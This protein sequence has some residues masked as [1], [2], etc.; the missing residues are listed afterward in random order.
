MSAKSAKHRPSVPL[1]TPAVPV[2]ST[3][4]A[5][6]STS[7]A[8]NWWRA[9]SYL[10]RCM[11]WSDSASFVHDMGS[12]PSEQHRL[13]HTGEACLSCGRCMECKTHRRKCNVVWSDSTP[14]A[15]EILVPGPDG[16]PMSLAAHGRR[17]GITRAAAS[18][19]YQRGGAEAFTAD[20]EANRKRGR[21]VGTGAC[22]VCREQGKEVAG[23]NATS[24]DAWVERE[25]QKATAGK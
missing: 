2:V 21:P 18:L 17:L 12:R 6:D 3:M 20:S 13:I 11:E 9:R 7:Y 19:R 22:S 15:G 8:T 14:V 1:V 5:N 24:H 4:S 25:R 23:H 10:G 16:V